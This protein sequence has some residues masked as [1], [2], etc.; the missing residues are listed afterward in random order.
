MSLTTLDVLFTDCCLRYTENMLLRDQ[1][2]DVADA[3]KAYP[4]GL[5]I[6]LAILRKFS[7]QAL[8][9]LVLSRPDGIPL[10]AGYQAEFYRA[11]FLLLNAVI[12]VSE[13][14]GSSGFGTGRVDFFLGFGRNIV[15]ELLREGMGIEEHL[16]RFQDGGRYHGWVQQKEIRN[17]LC[18]NFCTHPNCA[19]ISRMC[20]FLA[21]DSS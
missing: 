10:E 8:N 6:F 15:F 16:G 18:I 7:K 9:Q 20:S 5:A 17:Y 2:I 3:L 19:K 11:A 4:D 21:L 13:W 12:L 14:T 1:T